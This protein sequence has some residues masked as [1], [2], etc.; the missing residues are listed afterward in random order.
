MTVTLLYLIGATMKM[1]AITGGA[2]MSS[3]GV[4]TVAKSLM[5]LMTPALVG[6]TVGVYAKN[7]ARKD[8]S[9]QQ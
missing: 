6:M 4:K 1:A 3:E 8:G 5:M 7:K 9:D 2:P